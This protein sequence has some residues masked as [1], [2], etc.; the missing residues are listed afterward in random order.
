M[1][2]ESSDARNTAAWAMSSVMPARGIG[3]FLAMLAFIA[4]A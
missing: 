4:S 3:W 2:L 1:K